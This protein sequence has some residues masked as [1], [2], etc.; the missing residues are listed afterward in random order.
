V[1]IFDVACVTPARQAPES[2]EPLVP[3]AEYTEPGAKE[4]QMNAW[5]PK[6]CGLDPTTAQTTNSL[7][8]AAGPNGG[9]HGL[10][11]RIDNH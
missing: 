9:T 11:G 1:Q 6:P 10:H 5:R 7:F 8:F 3:A 4:M 2:N